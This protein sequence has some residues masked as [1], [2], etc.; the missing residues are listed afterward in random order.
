MAENL[1]DK[2]AKGVAWGFMDNL[3]G[4]G[5]LAVVN[6][7]LANILTPEEFGLIGMTSIFITL[8]TA[9]VDSGFT[10]ALTR[11]KIVS[12]DDLN[13]VFYFNVLTAGVLY[14]ILWLC[15]PS[16]AG[17]F[18]QPILTSIIR[19]IG[20]S[21][22]LTAAGIVQ[23]VQLIRKID[24]RTQ[25]IISLIA[26]LTSGTVGIIMALRGHGVWSLVMLQLCRAALTTILLWIFSRWKPALVFSGKSFHEMFS[27][28]GKLLIS[29]IISTLW[30]EIYSLI[31]G[32]MYSP[33]TLGQYT[34]A[35]KFKS[36][37]TS[38]IGI[39]VQRVSYPVLSQIQ[40]EQQ[41]QAS[42]YRRI[43][44]TTLMLSSAAV[45]GLAAI[46]K[47]AVLLLIGDQ[48][49]P[50][51]PYLQVLCFSGLFL[52]VMIISANVINADGRS[53]MTLGLEIFKTLLTV[54]P[55]ML[56]I[57]FDIE[58]LLWGMVLVSVIAS[59]AYS[60]GVSKVIPYTMWQQF[61]DCAPIFI[62]SAV[63]AA[64][65]WTVS[66]ARIPLFP[67]L[68]LQ[69]LLG[70]ALMVLIYEKIFHLD[71]YGEVKRYV[72]QVLRQRFSKLMSDRSNTAEK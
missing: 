8:S 45:L 57:W 10:G 38:N 7:V 35:D 44:R 39:V 13:T 4:T 3:I 19:L 72:V 25:A 61:K 68:V 14:L 43:L 66:L 31:I 54:I 15:A 32:K 6:I 67:M 53:G 9:L 46:A 56:G 30:T 65:V 17:F 23:K 62:A 20:L 21:L 12:E 26:S 11:K 58:A 36:L 16:I 70:V 5:I 48:W 55:I 28:G 24:F 59:L 69:I 64:L 33:G 50:S 29:S 34:R 47:P 60:Y 49:I 51:I 41:R 2:T 63:M 40:D 22:V 27:F 1:K 42:I 52:P 18:N 71:E 37:V